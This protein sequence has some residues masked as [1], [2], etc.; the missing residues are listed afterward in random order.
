VNQLENLNAAEPSGK[1]TGRLD[2]QRLGMFG[3]SFGGAQALQFCHDDAR[4]KA[5]S[6]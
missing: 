4:C 5:E 1:F 2:L 6:T 3:H